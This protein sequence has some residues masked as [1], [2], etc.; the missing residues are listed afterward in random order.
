MDSFGAKC[1]FSCE[2]DDACR[3]VYEQNYGEVPAGDITQIKAGDIPDCDML[4]AGFPCQ[5]FTIAGTQLGFDDPRGKLFFELCRIAEH[6]QP[7]LLLLENVPNLLSHNKGSTFRTVQAH[8]RRFGYDVFHDVLNASDFGVPQARKRVYMV[9][10]RQGML[11][12]FDFPRPFKT[13]IALADVLLPASETLRWNVALEDRRPILSR[14]PVARCRRPVRVGQVNGG[15]MGERIY[16]ANGHAITLTRGGGSVGSKT[17]LYL[18]GDVVRRL[19]PRECARIS[20]FPEAFKLH[21][22]A[23]Q[24]QMQFGNTIVVDVIQHI[25]QAL[26]AQGI[27]GLRPRRER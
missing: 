15:G 3:S 7:A 2:I 27:L 13:D 20:G 14:A 17:G 8:L 11:D 18:V 19:A 5:S 21:E 9:C 6:C 26:V 23:A 22:S 10:A 16:H 4:C 12:G 24:A 25:I 1:V